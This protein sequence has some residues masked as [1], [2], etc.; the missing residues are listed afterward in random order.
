MKFLQ[1]KRRNQRD[2]QRRPTQMH[3]SR[4]HVEWRN[5]NRVPNANAWTGICTNDASAWMT[6]TRH[7]RDL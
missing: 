7:M 6:Q 3:G 5:R 1:R 4:D 2:D